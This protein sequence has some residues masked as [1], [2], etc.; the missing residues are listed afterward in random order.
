MEKKDLQEIPQ[1]HSEDEEA[2]F[3]LEHDFTD[4]YDSS[5]WVKTEFPNLGPSTQSVFE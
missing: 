5:K 2:A 1:F 3:W 4:Y